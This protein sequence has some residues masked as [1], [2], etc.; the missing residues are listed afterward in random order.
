MIMTAAQCTAGLWLDSSWLLTRLKTK[1][2]K[3]QN[4]GHL[5]RQDWSISVSTGLSQDAPG[6]LSLSR[7]SRSLT[8]VTW[9]EVNKDVAYQA[10]S[11]SHDPFCQNFPR[12]K[13]AAQQA[14]GNIQLW[15]LRGIEVFTSYTK[16]P[17]LNRQEL[18]IYKQIGKTLRKRSEIHCSFQH[19]CLI[20][21]PSVPSSTE[22]MKTP[23][24]C[25]L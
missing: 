20:D 6:S 13:N 24:S 2:L 5:E 1:Q 16:C 4:I 25:F 8:V 9:N 15:R 11:C 18:W 17:V 3:T 7:K 12:P 22:K 21:S 23:S 14:L 10:V 19:L